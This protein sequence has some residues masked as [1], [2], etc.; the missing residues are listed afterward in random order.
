MYYEQFTIENNEVMVV[1]FLRNVEI[2]F[3]YNYNSRD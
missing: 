3:L 2:V 1:L